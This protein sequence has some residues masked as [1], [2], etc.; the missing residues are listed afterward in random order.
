LTSRAGVP[1]SR[2]WAHREPMLGRPGTHSR[3]ANKTQNCQGQQLRTTAGLGGGHRERRSEARQSR[4]PVHHRDECQRLSHDRAARGP[5]A[6]HHILLSVAHVDPCSTADVAIR[7][8]FM[9][10][11]PV[12]SRAVPTRAAAFTAQR[13]M[14]HQPA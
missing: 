3:S 1:L 7:A 2:V 6:R 11:S 9:M 13:A 4:R 8:Q 14:T 5:R 12:S 10:S